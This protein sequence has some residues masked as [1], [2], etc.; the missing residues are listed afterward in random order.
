MTEQTAQQA[1]EQSP[2]FVYFIA[3]GDPA[4]A[5]KIGISTEATLKSRIRRIQGSNHEKLKVLG[6]I[7]FP[8]MK[9]AETRE[10]KL[11]EDFEQFQRHPKGT[12]GQEWFNPIQEIFDYINTN[13]E[14]CPPSPELDMIR[15]QTQIGPGSSSQYTDID[16]F[17]D[18]LQKN[19]DMDDHEKGEIKRFHDALVFPGILQRRCDVEIYAKDFHDVLVLPGYISVLEGSLQFRLSDVPDEYVMLI[20]ANGT[21]KGRMEINLETHPKKTLIEEVIKQHKLDDLDSYK[22]NPKYP[23]VGWKDWKRHIDKF[24]RALDQIAEESWKEAHYPS[25]G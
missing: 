11:H 16:E 24:I 8:T 7:R 25:P 2:G 22:P 5:I 14:I 10:Q 3:A 13:K 21:R 17:L 9:E 18:E 12:A 4:D 19:M 20:Y 15:L 23:S 1:W 6:L